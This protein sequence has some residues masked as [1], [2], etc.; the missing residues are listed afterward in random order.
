MTPPPA[1]LCANVL[2]KQP[3]IPERK[4]QELAKVRAARPLLLGTAVGW[5]RLRAPSGRPC[6]RGASGSGG[7]CDRSTLWA[8]AE[9]NLTRANDFGD[10]SSAGLALTFRRFGKCLSRSGITLHSFELNLYFTLRFT[11]FLVEEAQE[12]WFGTKIKCC[13]QGTATP[14]LGGGSLCQQAPCFLAFTVC[15][16]AGISLSAV[17]LWFLSVRN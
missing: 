10:A 3:V 2:W 9:C 5:E 13:G 15:F 6:V 8:P 7:T 1:D 12:L 14:M 4:Y 11:V 17:Q 16:I